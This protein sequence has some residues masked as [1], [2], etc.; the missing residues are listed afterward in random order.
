M[1]SYA[2]KTLLENLN[3][4]VSPEQNEQYNPYR[5]VSHPLFGLYEHL[6]AQLTQLLELNRNVT[7][8]EIPNAITTPN[9]NKRGRPR[10]RSKTPEDTTGELFKRPRQLRKIV[11]KIE[12]PAEQQIQAVNL[13]Y[14]S[15]AKE[16]EQ[17]HQTSLAV[18]SSGSSCFSNTNNTNRGIPN[19]TF[20]IIPSHKKTRSTS[21]CNTLASNNCFA[22]RANLSNFELNEMGDI[23]LID[24]RNDNSKH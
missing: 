2:I 24:N 7:M 3:D 22:A 11:P 10:T 15:P 13:S 20:N 5:H 8:V 23:V 9:C 1:P 12:K 6:H 14:D 4:T 19:C 21:Q 16:M 18:E 17:T